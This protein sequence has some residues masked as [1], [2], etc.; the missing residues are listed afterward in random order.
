[1][2]KN[3]PN[4]HFFKNLIFQIRKLLRRISQKDFY[5]NQTTIFFIIHMRVF[6][7]YISFMYITKF[8]FL[9]Y[10]QHNKLLFKVM[11]WKFNIISLFLFS[12]HKP[13]YYTLSTRACSRNL[14]LLT[15]LSRLVLST[16]LF[17]RKFENLWI[18]NV[19]TV[20]AL[21]ISE[22]VRYMEGSSYRASTIQD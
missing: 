4:Y 18:S 15:N 9:L 11:M 5:M 10:L 19:D 12:L 17:V 8:Q 16:F 6:I 2:G 3:Q 14:V 20:N 1:M 13:F 22:Y 7:S 21:Y